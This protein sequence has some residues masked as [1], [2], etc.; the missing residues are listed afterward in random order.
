LS[1]GFG[2][3]FD[4]LGTKKASLNIVDSAFGT[5]LS[6][7]AFSAIEG[8]SQEPEGQIRTD[9]TGKAEKGFVFAA[10]DKRDQKQRQ[11]AIQSHM[12]NL[13]QKK[14]L[15]NTGVNLGGQV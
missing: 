8:G 4:P 2:K 11:A 13:P 6:G 15:V 14:R 1:S 12:E 3:L 10:D 7:V 9:E 5:N